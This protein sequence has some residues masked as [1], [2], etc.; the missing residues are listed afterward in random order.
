MKII[1]NEQLINRNARIA[2]RGC[3]M[4]RFR[5]RGGGLKAKLT[6]LIKG[7]G[8]LISMLLTKN[9]RKAIDRC[10]QFLVNDPTNVFV[11]RKLESR[12]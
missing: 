12:L 5:N 3:E 10:E 8:P 1:K 6:A 11:L 9:R 4:E 2:L 7:I